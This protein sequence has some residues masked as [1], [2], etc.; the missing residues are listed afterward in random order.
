M[1]EKKIRFVKFP[2]KFND[3]ILV[4]DNNII[5]V[6]TNYHRKTV[7]NLLLDKQGMPSCIEAI[8]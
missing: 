5:L 8:K 4:E 7:L 3:V 2:D 1:S 6:N